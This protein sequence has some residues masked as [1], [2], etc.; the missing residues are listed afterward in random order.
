MMSDDWNH[1]VW[2]VNCGE[3]VSAHARV[4]FHLC[5]LT[6]SQFTGLVQ[7]VFRHSKFAHVMKERS[8]FDRLDQARIRYPQLLG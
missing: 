2:K 3:D 1:R 6:V 4:Q 8:S 5:E 7:Y